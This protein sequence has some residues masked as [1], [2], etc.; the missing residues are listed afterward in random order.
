MLF[1]KVRYFMFIM[2]LFFQ[3]ISPMHIKGTF[4]INFAS[5]ETKWCYSYIVLRNGT[6]RTL[7]KETNGWARLAVV[8]NC[9]RKKMKITTFL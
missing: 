8:K 6:Y 2:L 4:P 7:V 5:G 3:V 9:H 1:S